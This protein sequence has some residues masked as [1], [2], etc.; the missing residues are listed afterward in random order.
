[1][2][3]QPALEAQGHLAVAGAHDHGRQQI[4]DDVIVVAGVERDAIL[5]VSLR[6]ADR[7]VERA[8]AVE[9]GDLDRHDVVDGGE[10]RPESARQR[11]TAHRGLQVEAD[12][13]HLVGD[14]R[15]VL[16]QL[17][18][19]RALQRGERQQHGVIAQR[20]R[21]PGLLDRL[22]RLADRA[23]NHDQRLVGPVTCRLDRELQDRAIEPDLADRELRRVHADRQATRAGIEVVAA[24]ARCDCLSNWRSASSA[25]GCAGIT[26]PWR[27]VDRTG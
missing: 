10:P 25:S 15:A 12:Q 6:D 13:R 22:R 27:K 17:V 8:I 26:A 21:G 7:D 3:E 20:A 16:D 24:M 19:A 4:G 9:R 14:S 2:A 23:C 1:M 18:L 5:G 11:N